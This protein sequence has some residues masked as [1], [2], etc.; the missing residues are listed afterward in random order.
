MNFREVNRSN[1]VIQ[2]SWG[3]DTRGRIISIFDENYRK[4]DYNIVSMESYVRTAEPECGLCKSKNSNLTHTLLL[5]LDRGGGALD[6]YRRK[7]ICKAC[8]ILI[9][10]AMLRNK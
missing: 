3:I 4:I 7:I 5:N 2:G 8:A 10:E 6:I 1:Y 9:T